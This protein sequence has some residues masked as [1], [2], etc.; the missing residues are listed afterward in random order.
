MAN[1]RLLLNLKI[2]QKK[3]LKNYSVNILE[4]EY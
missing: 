3:A 4:I 1:I 2:E